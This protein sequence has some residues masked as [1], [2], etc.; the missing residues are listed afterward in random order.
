MFFYC[1][2]IF[3]CGDFLCRFFLIFF[4][5]NLLRSCCDDQAPRHEVIIAGKTEVT[6]DL[7]VVDE[8]ET[9]LLQLALAYAVDCI[10]ER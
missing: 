5:V 8:F 9:S 2:S 7:L 10:A 1:L 4:D 3:L 6:V